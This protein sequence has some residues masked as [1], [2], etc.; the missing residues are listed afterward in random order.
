LNFSIENNVHCIETQ[1]FLEKVGKAGDKD[2]LFT[3][4]PITVI[5]DF[6]WDK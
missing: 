4:I 1:N 3:L 6:W 2:S 5:V